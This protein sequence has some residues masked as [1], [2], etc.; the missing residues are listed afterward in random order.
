[1]SLVTVEL[2]VNGTLV[3][4][5]VQAP[6]IVAELQS[7]FASLDDTPLLAALVG[8]TRRGP[9]GHPVQTLWHCF[10]A[11]YVLGLASTA[12]M[13][14]TLRNNPFIAEA[15]GIASPDAIPHEATFS[16][17]FAR[18]STYNMA[19]KVKDV[20]RSLV[21]HHYASLPGFGE[22][23]AFDSTT[24]AAWSNPAK[25]GKKPKKIATRG[26]KARVGKVSDADAGWSVKKG[27]QGVK[28]AV[29]GYKLHL[30]VDCE[31][32]LPIAANVSAGNVHDVTRASNLFREART[33][34]DLFR[35]N[36]AIGDAGYSSQELAR[37]L[38]LQ[39]GATPI[40]DPHPKHKAML[41]IKADFG[42][43]EWKALYKQRTAV[44][45]V[46]SRLK[47]QRSLND[48]TVRRL[49]K[50]TLHCYLSLIALQ[51]LAS[52]KRYDSQ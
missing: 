45:R 51:A 16:R 10:I 15:C 43:S 31:Y 4:A 29:F 9:K 37:L 32:E 23:V 20:S 6:P 12:A 50:V 27:T 1:M 35:P 33:A 38:R 13:I 52:M 49:R 47:G 8:P 26:Y 17:F 24:L 18:L 42:T 5:P 39:Y 22:R 34:N 7:V 41:S 21:Q 25:K 2:R 44:E 14:R 30:L 48:I 46:N 28:E 3:S 40:I 36:Y 19:A 11:K